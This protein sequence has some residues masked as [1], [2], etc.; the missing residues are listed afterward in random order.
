MAPHST[1]DSDYSSGSSTPTSAS[2]AGDGF[3]AGLNGLNN[4]RAV[5]PQ[6]PIAIIG[7][8]KSDH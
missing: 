6:E 7:M 1:L 5:D 3:V 2:A 8:G 4:G